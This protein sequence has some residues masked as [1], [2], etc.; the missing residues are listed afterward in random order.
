[1]TAGAPRSA[2]GPTEAR[3]RETTDTGERSS[4]RDRGRLLVS[5]NGDF[6][7]IAEDFET[8]RELLALAGRLAELVAS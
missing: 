5:L 8:E 4:A 2:G 1:M 7:V 3:D 6:R